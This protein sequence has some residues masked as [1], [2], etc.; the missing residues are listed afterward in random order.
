MEHE[1]IIHGEACKGDE[2]IFDNFADI[3][4]V[5]FN[6]EGK[7]DFDSGPPQDGFEYLRRTRYSP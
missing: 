3:Q 1:S 7:P 6:V 2:D 5:A 4:K